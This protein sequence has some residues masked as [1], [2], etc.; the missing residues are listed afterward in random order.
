ML[1]IA[2]LA[3]WG[4]AGGGFALVLVPVLAGLFIASEGISWWRR[5]RADRRDRVAGRR[6]ALT[7]LATRDRLG[8]DVG[9]FLRDRRP[10]DNLTLYLFDLVGFKKYND[11]FGYAAGDALLRHLA[12]RLHDAVGGRGVLYRLRG[13][14]FAFV[15]TA[16]PMESHTLRAQ[17][18]TALS[19][20]GE[21]FLVE[22]ASGTATIPRQAKNLSEALK[23]ADQEVQAERG[24]LRRKG[25]DEADIAPISRRNGM[26]PSPFEV[27][28][29]AVNVGHVLGLDRDDL[30]IVQSAAAW[31]DVGMMAI[32]EEIVHATGP[33]SDSQWHFVKLHT[34]VGERL[35]RANFGLSGVADVVRSSHER[36][37]G[38]GYP[39]GRT[40]D[41]IPLGARIV[42]VCSAFQDMTAPRAHRTALSAEQ[43]L[44]ELQRNAGA[45]FDPQ[46]VA[47]FIDAF[48]QNA[49]ATGTEIGSAS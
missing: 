26:P 24:R 11:A 33:L 42:F 28:E 31:R 10:D 6:D 25:I 23:L 32:P 49:G 14:Q 35:L 20:R 12:R 22:P 19:E 15:S 13:A 40:G 37:D 8:E 45:Q 7:G 1:A 29:L 16:P 5:S 27:A 46:V 44:T 17:A 47:A 38:A 34:L 4:W 3:L 9:V 36:W 18:A 21:G 43:A 48:S 39:E 2:V 41:D 30:E